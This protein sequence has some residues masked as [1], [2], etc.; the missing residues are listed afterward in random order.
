MLLQM[1]HGQQFVKY[2][3]HRGDRVLLVVRTVCVL[4]CSAILCLNV[5]LPPESLKEKDCA[6]FVVNNLKLI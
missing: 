2:L 1:V 6:L 4:Y 3:T 5:S